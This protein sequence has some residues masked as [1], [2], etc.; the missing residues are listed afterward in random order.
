MPDVLNLLIVDDHPLFR[1]GLKSILARAPRFAVVGEAGDGAEG[2]AAAERLKPDIAIIDISLPDASG[3]SLTRRFASVAP[4]CRIL[5]LSMHSKGDYIKQAFQ[6][7][8]QGYMVKESATDGL[9]TALE[10]I[11]E[12]RVFIDRSVSAEVARRLSGREARSPSETDEAY[13]RLTPRE[14]E[15]FR[16]LAE[17][18]TSKEIAQRLFIAPKTVENHRSNLTSKLGLGNPVDLLRY[19]ARIG[20]IDIDQWKEE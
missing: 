1:E 15:I 17:G 11:A 14:Q 4:D 7:G 9:L 20:L 19:A 16:L 13:G 18:L 3:I 6:A 2:L 10:T 8:A 12:G 5:I